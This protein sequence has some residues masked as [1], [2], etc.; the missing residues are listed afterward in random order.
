MIAALTFVGERKSQ[1]G[2]KAL[3]VGAGFEEFAGDSD[4]AVLLVL[5]CPLHDSEQ[6]NDRASLVG[7]RDSKVPGSAKRLSKSLDHS[8][9]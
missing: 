3:A 4:Y 7:L 2:E 8:C 1:S 9:V 5:R 6:I